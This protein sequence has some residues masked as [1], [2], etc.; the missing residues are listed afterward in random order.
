VP[1]SEPPYTPGYGLQP[2][3]IVGRDDLLDRTW[4]ALTTGPRH[5]E[6]HQAWIGERGVGK[7]VAAQSIASR[8]AKELGWAVVRYQAIA[9]EDPLQALTAELPAALSAWRRRGRDF[10]DLEKQVTVTVDIGVVAL[11]AAVSSPSVEVPATS[12][13]EALVRHVG[14]FARSHGTGL[15][16]TIDEAHIIEK[17]RSLAALSRSMQTAVVGQ[18]P[19]AVILT[20][21]PSLRERFIG[22]GTFIQRVQKHELSDLS[23]DSSRLALVEPAARHGALFAPDALEFLVDRAGGRPYYVQLFGYHAWRAAGPADEIGLSHAETGSADAY[24]QLDWEFQPTWLALSPQERD[25]LYAVIQLGPYQA[26]TDR[27]AQ[28][29]SRTTRQLSTARDRLINTHGAL[30]APSLG[31]VR[32]RHAQFADW[33]RQRAFAV[34]PKALRSPSTKERGNTHGGS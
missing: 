10:R 24:A 1:S 18:L 23:P 6:F 22:A 29:L 27:V 32:F 34:A 19:V 31:I 9:G 3:L 15:L 8:V 28:A 11:S 7:T 13:F 30:Q 5:P 16:L 14:A 4:A 17:G 26:P 25:Y 12:Q 21:L 33:A 20:G 2:P